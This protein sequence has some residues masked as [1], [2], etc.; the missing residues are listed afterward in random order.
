MI[1]YT[2]AKVKKKRAIRRV[3]VGPYNAFLVL[4]KGF[5]G[6]FAVG[7]QNVLWGRD[8]LLYVR[9][10]RGYKVAIFVRNRKWAM[11]AVGLYGPV[12]GR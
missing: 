2:R 6:V 3:Y 12:S 10:S 8:L 9:F 11:A 5:F 4:K 7:Y 1:T